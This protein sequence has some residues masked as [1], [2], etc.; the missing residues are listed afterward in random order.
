MAEQGTDDKIARLVHL[1]LAA[2]DQRLAAL[3]EEF[4]QLATRLDAAEDQLAAARPQAVATAGDSGRLDRLV[5]EMS[6]IR[7]D[8]AGLADRAAQTEA[9]VAAPATPSLR[10]TQDVGA[11]TPAAPAAAPTLPLLSALTP[12]TT[13]TPSAAQPPA[14]SEASPGS[15]EQAEP[16]ATVPASRSDHGELIDLDKL[17]DL[18]T[19]RLGQLNL[20]RPN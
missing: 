12:L 2:V 15:G 20:P 17:G 4:Q 18:L 14:A 1:V 16:A 10:V 19:A 3:R 7:A 13:S 9:A 11:A 6:Q 8:L 5:A